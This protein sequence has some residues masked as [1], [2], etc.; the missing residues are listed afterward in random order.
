MRPRPTCCRCHASPCSSTSADTRKPSQAILG[1]SVWGRKRSKS[2][3][4][5]KPDADVSVRWRC[6]SIPVV[7]NGHCEHCCMRAML[8]HPIY[9]HIQCN[10]Y[11]EANTQCPMQPP[12]HLQGSSI[13]K[14]TYSSGEQ[15]ATTV[16]LR[17][18]VNEGPPPPPPPPGAAGC[19]R[20]GRRQAR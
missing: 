5:V 11:K 15:S 16:T 9:N 7:R 4:R 13:A 19:R 2:V 14:S 8:R 12:T 10:C 3:L 20:T 18:S 6:L 1:G 17:Y